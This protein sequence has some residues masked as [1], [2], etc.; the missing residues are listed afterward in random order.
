M[1]NCTAV[2]DRPA[3]GG[4]IAQLVVP[5]RWEIV[6]ASGEMTLV[7]S[8]STTIP[9]GY[10]FVLDEN[11]RPIGLRVLSPFPGLHQARFMCVGYS[12]SDSSTASAPTVTL[13]VAGGL[14]IVHFHSIK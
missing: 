11:S 9:D 3:V 4:G 8:Q 10:G 6:T 12:A 5:Q 1:F 7:D 13:E 2:V 14:S